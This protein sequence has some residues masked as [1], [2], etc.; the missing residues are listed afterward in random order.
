MVLV[1]EQLRGFNGVFNPEIIFTAGATV[2]ELTLTVVEERQRFILSRTNT[3]HTPGTF[4]VYAL[5]LLNTPT[6]ILAVFEPGAKM[7]Y[8]TG[9]P[10]GTPPEVADALVMFIEHTLCVLQPRLKFWGDTTE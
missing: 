4:T 9:P 6:P 8:D 3:V 10:L 1:C 5:M 7:V 2:L